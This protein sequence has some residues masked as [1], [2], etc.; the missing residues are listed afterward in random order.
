MLTVL[1]QLYFLSWNKKTVKNKEHIKS[2]LEESN[3]VDLQREK[4]CQINQWHDFTFELENS[5][6]KYK[7]DGVGENPCVDLWIT[8]WL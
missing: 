2:N 1:W 7:G 5:P 3:K 6:W 8:V 4:L